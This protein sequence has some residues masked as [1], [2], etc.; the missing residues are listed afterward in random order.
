[1]PETETLRALAH[2]LRLRILSLLTGTAMSAAE[3][4]RELGETHANVS[5][6]FRRLHNAGLIDISEEVAIR[7]GQAKRYRHDPDTGG[8]L[9]PRNTED[10]A[11]LAATLGKELRRRTTRRNSDVPDAMTDA[12]LWV[13]PCVWRDL[14]E[15][16]RGIANRL[17]DAARPPRTQGTVPISAVLWFFEM[18]PDT[19]GKS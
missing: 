8:K 4:A 9:R 2:P 15:T 14:L 13:D 7:G 18:H 1:V 12:E 3:A 17:H 11:L 10:E 5:Y 19:A 6:H 16:V